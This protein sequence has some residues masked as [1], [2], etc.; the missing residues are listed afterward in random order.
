MNIKVTL[1]TVSVYLYLRNAALLVRTAIIKLTR[2]LEKI[3]EGG[4][5]GIVWPN[6]INMRTSQCHLQLHC[7]T[8]RSSTTFFQELGFYVDFL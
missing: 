6:Q 8:K 4:F 3:K 2:R 5:D 1:W 7:R